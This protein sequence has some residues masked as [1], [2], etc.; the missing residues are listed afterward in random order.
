MNI[1]DIVERGEVGQA[2][3]PAESGQ[4]FWE[5]QTAEQLREILDRGLAAGDAFVAAAA[6]IERRA[7]ETARRARQAPE[8]KDEVGRRRLLLAKLG[9]LLAAVVIGAAIALYELFF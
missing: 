2:T 5:T 6:E 4:N 1:G 3:G 7:G 8:D 9:T